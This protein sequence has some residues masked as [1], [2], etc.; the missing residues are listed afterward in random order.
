MSKKVAI[1]TGALFIIGIVTFISVDD[2]A[3]RKAQ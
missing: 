3:D 2:N 1:T